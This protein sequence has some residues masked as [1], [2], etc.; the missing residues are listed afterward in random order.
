MDQKL[1]IKR[2]CGPIS[3]Y[4]QIQIRLIPEEYAV[5]QPPPKPTKPH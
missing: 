2:E 5:F 1:V 4:E 3:R